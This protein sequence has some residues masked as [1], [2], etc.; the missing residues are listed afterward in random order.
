MKKLA[1]MIMVLALVLS[2]GTFASAELGPIAKED[3]KVGFIYASAIGDEGYT[4]THNRGR[5]ALEEMGIETMYLENIPETSDCEKAARDLIDQGC[6]VIIACSFGFGDAMNELS[7]EYPDI[8]FLHFSGAMKNDTNF[9][10]W[11]GSMEE[12]RYLTGMA[13][14]AVTESNILGYVAAHPYTE[15]QIGINAFTLGVV[16]VWKILTVFV[17]IFLKLVFIVWKRISVV[18]E[19]S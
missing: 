15:V 10:N 6:N 2:M 4:F 13:A 11:F 3:L 14:G 5:L 17:L 1:I 8:H 9:D 7:A 18:P 16:L 12:A 19:I